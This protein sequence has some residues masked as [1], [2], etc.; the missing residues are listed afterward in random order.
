MNTLTA[1]FIR[2]HAHDDVKTLALQGAR[3]ADVDMPFA[4][5]QI[6]GR[7][8]AQKKLPAWAAV[9]DILYP[10][11]LSMEQCSS[12]PTA[13][14]KAELAAQ[15]I[16]AAHQSSSPVTLVDLTGGFGV[17]FSFMARAFQQA[18]YVERQVHLCELASHN[19][20]ALGVAAEVVN[21]DAE[22]YLQEMG[23]VTMVFLDPARRDNQGGRTYGIADCTPNVLEMLPSLLQ[24]AEMVMLKLSPMLDWKKTVS[25]L[26]GTL[27]HAGYTEFGVMEVHIV[28]VDNE[29]K[30]LLVLIGRKT[31]VPLTVV[32]KNDEAV[33][34]Y[35]PVS[36]LLSAA[37]YVAPQPG[38]Q[39]LVPN[40]ALMKA[41]CF[42]ELEHRYGVHQI[43]VNSHLMV[44]DAR[45]VDFPGRHFT[46]DAICT[47]NKKEL[48]EALRDIRQANVAVRNFPMSVDELRKR[49]KI[50]E[51]GSVFIFATTLTDQK[52]VLLVCS[53][54]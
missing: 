49:L 32:C 20:A 8:T 21:A 22:T 50:K 26:D 16:Q 36:E 52:R 51:G 17:D 53:K 43:A 38:N 14:Y 7:Q 23:N 29:C 37:S 35:M 2:L 46:V 5:N 30:E 54:K 19:L 42:A 15:A 27:A 44:S 33:F 6:A 11:H 12:E 3:N 24:K 9:D 40:A 4:L 25:D 45:I 28:A 47:M 13:R 34:A 10:P 31:E 18:V 41:G 39:L 1:E 48:R